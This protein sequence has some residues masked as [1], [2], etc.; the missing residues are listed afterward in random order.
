MEIL[1]VGNF[2]EIYI[3]V[4]IYFFTRARRAKKDKGTFYHILFTIES[5]NPK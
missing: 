4:F 1:N 3:L 2:S 5:R